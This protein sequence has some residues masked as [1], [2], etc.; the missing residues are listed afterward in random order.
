MT[1]T[2]APLSTNTALALRRVIWPKADGSWSM[3]GIP[4]VPHVVHGTDFNRHHLAQSGKVLH[5]ELT[6]S[7]LAWE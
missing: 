4:D 7:A 5:L 3:C 6:F 2:G 1:F